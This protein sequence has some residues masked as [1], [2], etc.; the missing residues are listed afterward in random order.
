MNSGLNKMLETC[1]KAVFAVIIITFL[2]G[3]CAY[4]AD[5]P[6][7]VLPVTIIPAPVE[8]TVQPG[9]YALTCNTIIVAKTTEE[10]QVAKFLAERLAK[11]TE[12]TPKIAGKGNGISLRIADIPTGPEGYTLTAN[13]GGIEIA[14]K[15]AHG[16]FWGVQ[17][18]FQLLP[19]QVYGDQRIKNANWGVAA[20]TIRDEPR[21]PWRGMQLDV[22][23]HFFTV[24]EVEKF[25]DYAAMH[26]MNI[27]HWH[28]TEDQGWRIEIKKYPKLTEVGSIRA[29]SPKRDSHGQVQDGV[30]YGPFFYTQD[31]I[32]EVV[33]YAGERH[34]EVIPEIEMPGHSVAA[35][36]AYPELGCTGGPYQVRT[37]WGVADDVFCAGNEQTYK[38]LE[39]VIDEVC[40]L[41]P[42]QYIHIGGDECPK[43]RWDN[44]PK[45]QERMKAENLKDTRELQSYF[46]NRIEKYVNRKGKRIIGWDEIIEGGLAP[47]ATVMAWRGAGVGISAAKAGHD[48]IMTPSVSYFAFNESTGPGEPEGFRGPVTLEDVYAFD[49]A[50]G[51]PENARQHILGSE[52]CCWSEYFQDFKKVEYNIL[53]RMS[54][55]AE[56]LWSPAK[57]KDFADYCRR[58]EA[59]IPRYDAM[60]ANYRLPLDSASRLEAF[61]GS[62]SFSLP[63]SPSWIYRFTVDGSEPG[64]QSPVYQAAVEI[65]NN[66]VVKYFA[67][68]PKGKHGPVTTAEFRKMT[69]QPAALPLGDQLKPGIRCLLRAG[70]FKSAKEVAASVATPLMDAVIPAIQI[71]KAAPQDHFGAI[72][73]GFLKVSQDGVY[74]FQLQSDDGSIFSVGNTILINHDGFHDGSVPKTGVIALKAGWHP[75]KVEY[76][77]GTEAKSILLRVSGGDFH[78]TAPGVDSLGVQ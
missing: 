24:A 64:D 78:N 37:T 39:G 49:P 21:F 16:L 36:T 15:T 51:V 67:I 56:G 29:S 19:S 55:L 22:G 18:L 30:P 72:Y 17:T 27:F 31:Q 60:Q 77:Q 45:C 53:P 8:M 59:Q 70:N 41:F 23:R 1:L 7:T 68:T 46:V 11:T 75:V 58:L 42:S 63:A 32:R 28:L 26:K 5:N 61:T 57:S 14:G 35:L 20:V 52:G 62:T 2:V 43:A 76:F 12:L 66:T 50:A 71:P 47:N 33:A 25:L 6:P 44:C 54:A 40:E 13:A 69:I 4:A 10:R 34:I 48:V 9:C 38:L 74:T 3:M 73:Q 65:T